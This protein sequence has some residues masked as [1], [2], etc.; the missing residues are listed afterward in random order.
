MASASLPAGLD[1]R[2]LSEAALRGLNRIGDIWC[3]RNGDHPSFSELGCIA[4][5][6]TLVEHAPEEDIAQLNTFL[7]LMS[8]MP[9]FFVRFVLWLSK[10]GDNWPDFIGSQLRLLNIGLRSL[11]ITLYYNGK[12]GPDYTGPTP[13]DLLGFQLNAV[14]DQ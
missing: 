14:R 2:F 6:D 12:T 4:H 3:P 8:V 9:G 7:A 13:H 1:S 11:C 5:I 10:T